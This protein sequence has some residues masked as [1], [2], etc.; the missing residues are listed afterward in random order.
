[1][2]R[3]LLIAGAAMAA[4]PLNATHAKAVEPPWCAVISMGPGAVYEDCQYYS[5]EACRPVV[6][7][8]NRGFCNHNPRYIA[9]ATA[10]KHAHHKRKVQ[11]D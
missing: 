5:F 10:T 9:P 8:G 1:M 4:M 6:L 2:I 3:I 7:A 11:Y